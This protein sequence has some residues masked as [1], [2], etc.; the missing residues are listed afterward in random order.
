MHV[1]LAD[2]M[3]PVLDSIAGCKDYLSSITID[4]G[5]FSATFLDYLLAFFVIDVI[6]SAI[7]RGGENHVN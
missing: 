7:F 2:A 4:F 5:N 1:N 6:I 3:Q